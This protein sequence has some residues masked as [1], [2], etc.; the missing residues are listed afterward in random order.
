MGLQLLARGKFSSSE[1][2]AAVSALTPADVASAMG[3]MLKVGGIP[4]PDS[5]VSPAEPAAQC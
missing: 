5:T 1:Y 4:L 2:A 3:A